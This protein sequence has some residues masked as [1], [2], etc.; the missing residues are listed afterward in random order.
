MLM[1]PGMGLQPQ[2]P[3]CH[4]RDSHLVTAPFPSF[5][6]SYFTRVPSSYSFKATGKSG[7]KKTTQHT[8]QING[9]LRFEESFCRTLTQISDYLW[10]SHIQEAKIIMNSYLLLF[11]MKRAQQFLVPST[12]LQIVEFS[13]IFSLVQLL[14]SMYVQF[15]QV[16]YYV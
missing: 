16:N 13:Y 1:T 4:H 5:Y 14:F 6:K 3:S 11:W 7:K 9:F 12:K 15:T 2:A 8:E 10:S